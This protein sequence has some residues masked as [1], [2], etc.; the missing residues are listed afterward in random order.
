MDRHGARVRRAVSRTH[1]ALL[2]KLQSNG[3]TCQ[4]GEDPGDG[5]KAKLLRVGCSEWHRTLFESEEVPASLSRLKGCESPLVP[6]GLRPD[7]EWTPPQEC[8]R[9]ERSGHPEPRKAS[10][11]TPLFT[12]QRQ[13]RWPGSEWTVSLCVMHLWL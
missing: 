10:G 3:Q 4:N 6:T 11:H 7:T 9:P 12:R 13:P 1:A 8:E 5:K 2:A